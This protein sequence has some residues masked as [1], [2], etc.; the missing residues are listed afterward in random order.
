MCRISE[1]EGALGIIYSNPTAFR[2]VYNILE[3]KKLNHLLKG[4]CVQGA[5]SV[6]G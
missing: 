1:Q 3:R 5:C 4:L 2:K 6:I